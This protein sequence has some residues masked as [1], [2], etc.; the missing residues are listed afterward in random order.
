MNFIAHNKLYRIGLICSQEIP[1]SYMEP[2]SIR[3]FKSLDSKSMTMNTF[4]S[5]STVLSLSGIITSMSCGTKVLD[6]ELDFSCNCLI[7]QISLKSLMRPQSWVVLSFMCLMAT[8]FP[9]VLHVALQTLPKVPSPTCFE[10]EQCSKT[11]YQH[12]CLPMSLS[13]FSVFSYF[14]FGETIVV[15]TSKYSKMFLVF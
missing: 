7:I 8:F 5:D 12:T 1:L 9:L 6:R 10:I 15:F 14:G 11:F 4:L 2:L 3:S 13:N